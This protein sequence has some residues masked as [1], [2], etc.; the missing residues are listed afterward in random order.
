MFGIHSFGSILNPPH[1]CILSVGAIER[2]VVVVHDRP[3]VASML[4]VTLT[5]DHRVV[6]GV[7][8]ARWLAAF[9]ELVESPAKLAD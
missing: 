5:C 6:D 2:R 1:G 8:G 9:K 7:V 4:T 3:S